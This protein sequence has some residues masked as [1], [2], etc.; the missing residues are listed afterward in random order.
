MKSS[1]SYRINIDD[2]GFCPEVV[3]SLEELSVYGVPL[4]ASWMAN[5]QWPSTGVTQVPNIFHGIHLNL[6]EGRSLTRG[7]HANADGFFFRPWLAFVF[8]SRKLK[9][10]VEGEIE[11]Q[12]CTARERIQ[13]LSHLDSHLHL[14]AIPWLYRLVL[15]YAKKFDIPWVRDPSQKLND[16]VPTPKT[17]LLDFLRLSRPKAGSD[18]RCYGIHRTFRMSS[19]ACLKKIE[20]EPRE[21][22]W[23]PLA[24]LPV[25]LP[26]GMRFISKEQ[27][28]L[29]VQEHQQLRQLLQA[30]SQSS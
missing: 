23:H 24:K 11:A 28:L 14:H 7:T 6:M 18:F 19:S 10:D 1:T 16:S 4:Y 27:M 30:L 15:N 5:F 22:I 25:I 12:I 26:E 2:V 17:L 21:F 8:P 20:Q 29:R 3:Q 13:N 9:L